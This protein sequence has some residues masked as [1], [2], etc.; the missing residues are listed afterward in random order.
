MIIYRY[1]GSFDGLLT[2]VFDMFVRKE[3][4]DMLVAYDCALPLFCDVLYDVC[5]DP[6]KA[7][8]VWKKMRGV[9]SQ[10]AASAYMAASLSDN[11]DYPTHAMKFARRAVLSESSIENDFSDP[12]VIAVVREARRVKGEAHRL[13]QFIRFQKACDGTYFAMIEP[14]FD[15]LPFA[16]NHF[17]DRFSDQ[18]FIIYDRVRDYGYHYDT[19]DVNRIVISSDGMHMRTGQLDSSMMDAEE[20]LFQDLWRGY[21]DAIAIKERS[22]P[23]KQ[24]A[25]MPV[26]YWKYLTEM[27]NPLSG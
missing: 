13:L 26:R 14:L 4:P 8:R 6:E 16:V 1:D 3:E 19:K 2:A 15:V 23:R 5:P 21:V 18:P 9:L 17:V 27:H 20:M 24:R 10:G 22:N 11:P 25:D 7:S 12:A